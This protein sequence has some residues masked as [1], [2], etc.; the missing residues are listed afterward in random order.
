M[1]FAKFATALWLGWSPWAVELTADA[2]ELRYLWSSERLPY[3]ALERVEFE[4]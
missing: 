1:L 3:G 2:V 4:V